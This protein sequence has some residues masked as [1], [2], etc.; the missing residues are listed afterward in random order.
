ML[1]PVLPLM[2]CTAVLHE[3]TLA[4]D[5]AVAT[6][7]GSIHAFAAG[8]GSLRARIGM[9]CFFTEANVAVYPVAHLLCLDL[10]P[11]TSSPFD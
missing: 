3:P 1:F 4:A 5:E 7:Q 2:V 9:G 6:R 11:P 10:F 8:L